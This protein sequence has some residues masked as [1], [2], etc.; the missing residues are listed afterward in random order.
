MAQREF[1]GFEASNFLLCGVADAGDAV[2]DA[3]HRSWDVEPF[4]GGESF[5]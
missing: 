3:E 5:S 1:N 2:W 4:S